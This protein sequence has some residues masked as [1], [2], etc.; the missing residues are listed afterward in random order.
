MTTV[1]WANSYGVS[2][3]QATREGIDLSKLAEWARP[4]MMRM[5]G[6]TK[7][8]TE[9]R[10][11]DMPMREPDGIFAGCNNRVWIISQDEADTLTTINTKRATNHAAREAADRLKREAE[12]QSAT[13]TCPKCG[14]W[15]YGDCTAS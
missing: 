5:I 15:C 4:L 7:T 12:E 1:E 10:L 6:E 11:G 13:P 14:T 2:I 3:Q 8:L 9:L